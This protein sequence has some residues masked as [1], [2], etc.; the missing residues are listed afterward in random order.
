MKG[1]DNPKQYIPDPE[2]APIVKRIFEMYASGIG[3]VKICGRLSTEKVVAPNGYAFQKTG[4]RCGNPDL[5]RSYHW[6][7][8]PFAGYSPIRNM[9][10]IP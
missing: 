6:A 7:Q 5:N 9:W 8:T 10:E 3:I 1:P 2:T 4:S